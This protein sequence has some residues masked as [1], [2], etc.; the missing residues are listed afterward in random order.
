MPYHRVIMFGIKENIRKYLCKQLDQDLMLLTCKNINTL[1]D[2]LEESRNLGGTMLLL[3]TVALKKVDIEETLFEL[4]VL[5]PTVPRVLIS[6][7]RNEGL[8]QQLMEKGLADNYIITPFN[9]AD[10]IAMILYG[11][12]LSKIRISMQAQYET[13]CQPW[14]VEEVLLIIK[15]FSNPWT[16]RENIMQRVSLKL[17]K[18]Y[19]RAVRYYEK[20]LY[21]E[22]K[23]ILLEVKNQKRSVPESIRFRLKILQVMLSH[24]S[25]EEKKELNGQTESLNN[26]KEIYN[27]AV[28][29]MKN[30][31]LFYYHTEFRALYPELTGWAKEQHLEVIFEPEGS[32]ILI[33]E[34]AEEHDVGQIDLEA[35]YAVMKRA[36]TE[37]A[38]GSE[39]NFIKN[40]YK[41]NEA[42]A[43]AFFY[44]HSNISSKKKTKIH[45][46]WKMMIVEAATL[47]VCRSKEAEA[48]AL[49]ENA[50]VYDAGNQELYMAI[51]VIKQRQGNFQGINDTMTRYREAVL[52][53]WPTSKESKRLQSAVR[54]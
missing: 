39:T 24:R 25:L 53:S 27:E 48:L 49:L 16:V 44:Q 18:D 19:Y 42:Y 45:H 1:F 10:M 5:D 30:L 9:K 36:I 4:A 46:Y 31:D 33:N 15:S 3:D 52:H 13:S 29:M 51:V 12:E 8:A 14:N 40:C 20:G 28:A 47:M 22:C 7:N 41:V 43:K 6:E 26:M 54:H 11:I 21:E 37:L 32:T 34:V 17:Y 23:S 2:I 50:L 35:L 38:F